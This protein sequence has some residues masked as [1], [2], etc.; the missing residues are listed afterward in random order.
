MVCAFTSENSPTLRTSHPSGRD[1]SESNSVIS[2]L[3]PKP[4]QLLPDQLIE[5]CT[6]CHLFTELFGERLHLVGKGF[7]I[8]FHFLS[9]N[10]TSGSKDMTVFGNLCEAHA[11]A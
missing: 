8:V 9:A 3:I 4:R 1:R 5:F 7:V 11:A 6:L 2:K 10:I